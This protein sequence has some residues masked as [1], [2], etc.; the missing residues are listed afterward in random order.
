[1]TRCVRWEGEICV[2]DWTPQRKLALACLRFTRGQHRSAI[3]RHTEVLR[4]S[5]MRYFRVSKGPARLVLRP[6]STSVKSKRY[7]HK[8]VSIVYVAVRRPWSCRRRN[9]EEGRMQREGWRRHR[10]W[11]GSFRS[12]RWGKRRGW[13]RRRQRLHGSRP[14]GRSRTQPPG[15]SADRS[16]RRTSPKTFAVPISRILRQS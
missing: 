3:S 2:G 11:W 6:I 16:W 1:M 13:P 5:V 14:L 12:T 10:E 15:S 4:S 8:N 7:E 9:A